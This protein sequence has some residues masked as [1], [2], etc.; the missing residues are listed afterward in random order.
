[1]AQ[2]VDDK[3]ISQPLKDDMVDLTKIKIQKKDTDNKRKLL[4]FNM[5]TC[6]INY[7]AANISPDGLPSD[8]PTHVKS[9]LFKENIG[10]NLKTSDET[11][12]SSCYLSDENELIKE[13]EHQC[14]PQ[15]NEIKTIMTKSECED[16]VGEDIDMLE[17][18]DDVHDKLEDGQHP[19][20][21][22]CKSVKSFLVKNKY[23][24]EVCSKTFPYESILDKHLLIHN[25]E[26]PYQC[27]TCNKGFTR[28]ND[29]KRHHLSHTGVK[30]HK[31][32]LCGKFFAQAADLKRHQPTHSGIKNHQCQIC[33]KTFTQA[34]SLKRH[35]VIHTGER[36]HQ[37]E[38]CSKAFTRAAHLKD[39]LLAHSGEK[40]YQ[41]FLCNKLFAQSSSLRTHQLL[42]IGVKNHECSICGKLFARKGDL[43]RHQVTHSDRRK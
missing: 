14:D 12:Q 9:D 18:D 40:P 30:S 36:A 37:C 19:G 25:G 31:C 41:C 26:K 20:P 6:E 15:M 16:Q 5:K 39:H 13:E 27:P 23:E 22:Q 4:N 28:S 29:L 2:T 10:E 21:S 32:T 34:A 11:Q 35:I 33:H 38:F 42:H 17:N 3:I 43:K 7:N 24:C 1:M 8:T